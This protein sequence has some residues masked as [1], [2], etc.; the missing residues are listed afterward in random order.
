MSIRAPNWEPS[1]QTTDP[2]AVI[3]SRM[4]RFRYGPWDP[5]YFALIGSLVGRALV[6][7]VPGTRGIHYRSTDTGASLAGHLASSHEWGATANRARL[8][9]KYF[10]LS[11]TRLKDFIYE[12]FP[13]VAGA[14]WGEV[15]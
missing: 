5:Q 3:E 1:S 15:L 10:D 7:P 2:V 12:Q 8:L 9:K 14:R 6:S 11:G 13:D 4:I